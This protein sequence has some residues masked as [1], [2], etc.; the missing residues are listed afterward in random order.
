MAWLREQEV[1]RVDTPEGRRGALEV[2]V[3]VGLRTVRAETGEDEAGALEVVLDEVGGWD[4]VDDL[5][6]EI[7]LAP[8]PGPPEGRVTGEALNRNRIAYGRARHRLAQ[9]SEDR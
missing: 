5:A 1:V 4:V 2:L 9:M 3:R 6:A 7:D 8:R